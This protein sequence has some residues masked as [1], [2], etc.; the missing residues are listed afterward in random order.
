MYK[1][2]RSRLRQLGYETEDKI[3]MWFVITGLD[4]YGW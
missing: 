2:L 3:A 1:Y 4:G